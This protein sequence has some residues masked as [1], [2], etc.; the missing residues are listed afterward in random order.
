[1]YEMLVLERTHRYMAAVERAHL[2]R[3]AAVREVLHRTRR[4]R[5]QTPTGR[6][7]PASEAVTPPARRPLLRPF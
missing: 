3:W 4:T 7:Q 5:G 1:M 6:A 2:D